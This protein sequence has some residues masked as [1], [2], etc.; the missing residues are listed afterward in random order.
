MGPLVH[1]HVHVCTH[2]N[3]FLLFLIDSRTS[4]RG[5]RE[6]WDTWKSAKSNRVGVFVRLEVKG[7]RVRRF[8][9][10]LVFIF[11]FYNFIFANQ[12]F[13]QP[14]EIRKIHDKR[15]IILRY[16]VITS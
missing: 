12:K 16:Y 6:P 5:G 9:L 8:R 4:T 14:F 10:K 13:L 7:K 3:L 11:H 15:S 1:T 2:K